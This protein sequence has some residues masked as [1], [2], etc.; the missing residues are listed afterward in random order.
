MLNYIWLG[1]I[2]AAVLIGATNGSMEAVS[3][4]AFDR[5]E[6]AVMKLALPLAG[7]MALWLGVDAVGGRAGLIQILAHLLRPIMRRLFPDVP[8]QHPAM[9]RC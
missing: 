3:K 9:V 4:E 5:V 1:L 6:F 2:V 7:I 8:V